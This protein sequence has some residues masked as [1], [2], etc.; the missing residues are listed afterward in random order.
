[1]TTTPIF[2]F[3]D[4]ETTG[5]EADDKILEVA[6]LITD[7][8]FNKISPLRTFIVEHGYQWGEVWNKLSNA[9]QIVRDM[10]HG[11]GLV[12]DMKSKVAYELDDIA[13]DLADD[14]H[15]VID[16]GKNSL[17]DV[18]FAGLSVEF[19]REHLFRQTWLDQQKDQDRNDIGW[20]FH[21]R[22][23]NLSAIKMMF[24]SAGMAYPTP[25]NGKPHRAA[26]DV[27]E[28]L[29]Q[30]QIFRHLIAGSAK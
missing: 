29:E 9:P 11:S 25:D 20:R 7:G 1:M 15:R 14:I 12:N 28:S 2:V 6:W 3:L 5:L 22:L 16:P 4:I 23:L 18:H 10:H 17:T 26:Y 24:E 19:D 8:Q 27:L 30:A 13:D 21:H